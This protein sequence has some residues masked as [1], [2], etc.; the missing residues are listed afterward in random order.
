MDCH[1][2]VDGLS[3]GDAS[4]MCLT[5]YGY[6]WSCDLDTLA[7][8]NVTGGSIGWGNRVHVQRYH[9]QT[10]FQVSKSMETQHHAGCS[11]RFSELIGLPFIIDKH[12]FLY[13]KPS[14]STNA[15]HAVCYC[16]QR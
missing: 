13:T 9:G 10:A 14:R 12:A 6:L 8:T 4:Q 1:F 15:M 16:E 3:E 7:S 2:G 11:S 5:I